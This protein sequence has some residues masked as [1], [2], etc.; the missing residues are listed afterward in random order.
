VTIPKFVGTRPAYPSA[1]QCPDVASH[2]PHPKGYLQHSDWADRMLKTHRQGQC[3][4]CGYWAIWT[5]KGAVT[6][7]GEPGDGSHA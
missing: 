1:D 4:T 6:K 2:T 3:P 7:P 5:P